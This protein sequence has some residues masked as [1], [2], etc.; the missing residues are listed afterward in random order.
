MPL[1]IKRLQHLAKLLAGRVGEQ[2]P[3]P[4]ALEEDEGFVEEDGQIE[5]LAVGAGEHQA[6]HLLH[7]LRI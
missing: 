3:H 5:G 7:H 4:P 2:G 6:D 1:Y